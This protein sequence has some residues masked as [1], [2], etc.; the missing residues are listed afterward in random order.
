MNEEFIDKDLGKVVIRRNARA[1]SIIARRKDDHI[2]L[3]VPLRY[4]QNQI[5]TSLELLKPRIQAL[6]VKPKY[7]FT[8]D[9]QFDT[10]T[11]TVNINTSA[12]SKFYHQLKNG[13]LSINC[14]KESLIESD[15]TQ[16]KIREIVEHYLRLEAK[17][18]LPEKVKLSAKQHNFIFTEVKINK[19]RTRWGSCSSKKSINLAY[20]CL[21]LPEY[22]L[23]FII[24]H[25]LCHTLEMNHGERFWMHLDRVTDNKA[26]KLT[27]ELKLIKSVW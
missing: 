13:V 25:E 9:S 23:D 7:T 22:L 16:M 20:W 8:K 12:L 15:D 17:R 1:K 4:K 27:A 19:S 2:L 6:K 10:L 5:M 26:Q 24:L 11:F 21:L 3:T 14:P 18:I